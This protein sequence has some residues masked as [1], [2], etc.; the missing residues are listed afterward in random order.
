MKEVKRLAVAQECWEVLTHRGWGPRSTK[1]NVFNHSHCP[2][3]KF[4][5]LISILPNASLPLS[6]LSWLL[7]SLTSSPGLPHPPWKETVLKKTFL[8]QTLV[9]GEY[10]LCQVMLQQHTYCSSHLSGTRKEQSGRTAGYQ[11]C[12][13]H[14]LP[15]KV[16]LYHAMNHQEI[17]I[18]LLAACNEC[19]WV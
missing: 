17:T 8:V 10:D 14:S 13:H 7:E 11:G 16:D 12:L 19:R 4:Y 9:P 15:K 5:P 18:N 3:G 1:T 2:C 6:A